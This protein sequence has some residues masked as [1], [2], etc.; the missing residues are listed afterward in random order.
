MGSRTSC[1]G[2]RSTAGT[3]NT[4]DANGKL[5]RRVRRLYPGD[6]HLLLKARRPERFREGAQVQVAQIVH[7][8]VERRQAVDAQFNAAL[9]AYQADREEQRAEY[10]RRRAFEKKSGMRLP[11]TVNDVFAFADGLDGFGA[12][13]LRRRLS[14]SVEGRNGC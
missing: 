11:T 1:S 6:L 8:G 3:R 4:L 13:R 10:E 9:D 7:G 2:A 12:E 5:L 14:S